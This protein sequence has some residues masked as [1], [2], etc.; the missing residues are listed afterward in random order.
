MPNVTCANHPRRAYAPTLASL[1][2]CVFL[3]R[4]S[5]TSPGCA[6]FY[7]CAFYPPHATGA[8][9]CIGRM[10]CVESIKRD[11]VPSIRRY[12]F[13][14]SRERE[15]PEEADDRRRCLRSL[16]LPTRQRTIE[17]KVQGCARESCSPSG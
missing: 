15:R 12:K 14:A 7:S 1:P 5:P 6:A 2:C 4:K 11:G 10:N 16:T 3:L 17:G 9:D 13:E 8:N